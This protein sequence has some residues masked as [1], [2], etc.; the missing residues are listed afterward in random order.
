MKFL[1]NMLPFS[2]QERKSM[3]ITEIIRSRLGWCPQECTLSRQPPVLNNEAATSVPSQG[4]GMPAHTR[5]L[6][7]YRNHVLLWAVFITLVSVPF[8]AYF[9]TT[10]LTRLLFSLGM[11]AGL[12]VFAFFGRW[13]WNSLNMLEK[14]MAINNGPGEYIIL[15]LIAGVIPLSVVLIIAAL[16]ALIQYAGAW[17]FPAFATGFAFIPWYVY[18]LILLW[19]R[20]TGCILVYDKKAWLFSAMECHEHVQ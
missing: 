9:Q 8:V 1:M 12:G 4:P 20:E 7:R 13:L 6:N 19:E 10:D 16:L 3:Q 11:I 17:A 18:I 5:W 15:F 2:N 14:G